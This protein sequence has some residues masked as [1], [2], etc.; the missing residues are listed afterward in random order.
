M[1]IAPEQ[2]AKKMSKLFTLCFKVDDERYRAV[3]AYA[4]HNGV[5]MQDLLAEVL[6]TW[7]SVK[8]V[9]PIKIAESKEGAK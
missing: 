8:K 2:Q 6:E 3:K 4:A 9:K 1:T 7:M 5:Q